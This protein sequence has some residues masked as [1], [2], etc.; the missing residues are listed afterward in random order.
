MC[1][2]INLNN[3]HQYSIKML[4]LYGIVYKY[5]MFDILSTLK[6]MNIYIYIIVL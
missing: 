2:K 6:N 5:V 4:C 3:L 1:V